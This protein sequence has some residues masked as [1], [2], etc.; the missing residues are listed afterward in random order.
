M[1][2]KAGNP[3]SLENLS[4]GLD[5][6][7]LGNSNA[8]EEQVS[9]PP[10]ARGDGLPDSPTSATDDPGAEGSL[11][12]RL[13]LK[14]QTKTKKLLHI[15]DDQTKSDDAPTIPPPLAPPPKAAQDDD[16]LFHKAPEPEGLSLKETIKHPMET[17]Q[18]AARAQGMEKFVE[19]LQNDV[20]HGAD[21][22]L[23]RAYDKIQAS[24]SDEDQAAVFE[25]LQKIKQS[26]QDSYVR[27]TM[28]RHVRQVTRISGNPVSWRDQADFIATN[29][30]G[31][32][33]MQWLELGRHVSQRFQTQIEHFASHCRSPL[34][35]WSAYC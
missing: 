5:R 34:Q 30:G 1:K 33:R 12:K 22:Q 18:S 21:V 15:H 11:S 17:V 8:V 29:E 4:R 31:K 27:W 24:K 19:S 26:R 20:T 13:L 2:S 25:D 23:V 3:L 35:I 6:G 10:L 28:D 16:R 14:T 7:P 32:L 9:A